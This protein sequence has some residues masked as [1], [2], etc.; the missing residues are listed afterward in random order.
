[1][2]TTDDRL[3]TSL[4]DLFAVQPH[5]AALGRLDE[6]IDRRLRSWTP[7]SAGAARVARLR[8]GRRAGVI[9]L[10]AAAFVIAG[11]NGSLKGLY[12][13]LAGPFDTPW[14]RG[15]EVNQSQLVDGYRVTIDRAYA[16]ATSL[17]LAISVVDELERPGTT[18]IEAFSTIVT[19]EAGEYSSGWG[20]VSSPDGAF[21][22]VNVAWKTP[23]VLPLPSGTR[24]IHVE[25]PFIRVRDD[26][27]PP[28][29]ADE[30]G[31]DPWHRVAGPWTFDF[32]ID[33]DGGTTITPDI[34]TEVDGLAVR[35]TR[36]IA[37][38]SVV[39]V[40]MQVEGGQPGDQ[41][42]PYGK[43]EIRHRGEVLSVVTQ[44]LKDDGSAVLM[45]DGGVSDASGAW[46]IT[47]NEVER[48]DTRLVGPWVLRFDA[49]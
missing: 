46:T 26:S 3:E 10:L 19:D 39:R 47:I 45:T 5:A 2:S 1:M 44:S 32:E 14:H 13:F 27:I 35:V 49:P 7:R 24:T 6:R 15:V 16:D 48:G 31:W 41:W 11:A 9:G 40:E 28:P 29:N 22:A 30:V 17:A 18:Q 12:F 34:V 23:A 43:I 36:V 42:W 37:A 4:F 20:A 8:P 33:V 25:L 21:A 38:S